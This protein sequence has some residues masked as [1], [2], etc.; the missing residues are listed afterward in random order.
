MAQ[1]NVGYWLHEDGNHQAAL[2]HFVLATQADPQL[3]PAQ[4]MV[5][6]LRPHIPQSVAGTSPYPLYGGGI[7]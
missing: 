3:R 4:A 6:Q 5:A 7:R 2:S 1:Y